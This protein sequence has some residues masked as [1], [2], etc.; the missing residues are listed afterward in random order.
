ML[1]KWA[2]FAAEIEEQNSYSDEK[3]DADDYF[4]ALKPETMVG[5]SHSTDLGESRKGKQA[6]KGD[7]ENWDARNI[8]DL[9]DAA[10]VRSGWTYLDVS[11]S[12]CPL[13]HPRSPLHVCNTAA[14]AR[15]GVFS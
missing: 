1:T 2:K 13:S 15:A 3:I 5:A 14:S 4:D 12:S 10:S 11:F 8:L 7:M 9:T 6:E